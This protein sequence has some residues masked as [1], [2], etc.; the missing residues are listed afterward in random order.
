LIYVNFIRFII[1]ELYIT[2]I[3]GNI[4]FFVNIGYQ[5]NFIIIVINIKKFDFFWSRFDR[6]IIKEFN[7]NF[8]GFV[9]CY[10][11]YY[12]QVIEG[13]SIFLKLSR[14]YTGHILVSDEFL[15]P[16]VD[17]LI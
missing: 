15:Q 17:P 3:A 12:Y 8:I 9:I 6:K 4:D 14:V 10:K 11:C 16:L 5:F 7:F 2:Y 1:A 13:K